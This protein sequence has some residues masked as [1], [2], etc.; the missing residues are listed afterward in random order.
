MVLGKEGIGGR[1]V[2]EGQDGCMENEAQRGETLTRVTQL[3][4][5]GGVAD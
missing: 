2:S 4:Q 1:P 5:E 3:T